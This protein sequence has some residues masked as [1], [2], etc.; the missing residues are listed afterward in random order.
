MIIGS[1]GASRGGYLWALRSASPSMSI[2]VGFSLRLAL[3]SRQKHKLG[4]FGALHAAFLRSPHAHATFAV[5]DIQADFDRIGPDRLV[6]VLELSW[7]EIG[8]RHFEPAA[9]LAIGP[10]V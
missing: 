5:T 3:R 9:H 7:T 8:D 2:A 4:D 10:R 6:D 1:G